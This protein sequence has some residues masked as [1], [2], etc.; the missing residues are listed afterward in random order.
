MNT[1]RFDSL[2][3]SAFAD[4]SFPKK[5]AK[6]FVKLATRFAVHPVEIYH[7]RF[8][9]RR[10]LK[11]IDQIHVVSRGSFVAIN[12]YSNG[13]IEFEWCGRFVS[14]GL[15]NYRGQDVI[16]SDR[17]QIPIDEFISP[18]VLPDREC[19]GTSYG[20]IDMQGRPPAHL[21]RKCVHRAHAELAFA[22]S[23]NPSSDIKYQIN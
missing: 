8:N 10:R 15:S 23:S 22:I 6:K 17:T 18:L 4:Y 20:S 1:R 9:E 7:E 13:K 21:V 3:F 19:I 5:F 14:D 2:I 16:S 12:R 11:I